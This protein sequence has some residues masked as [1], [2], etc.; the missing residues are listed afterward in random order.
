VVRRQ[1]NVDVPPEVL[2]GPMGSLEASIDRVMLV[3]S[4]DS[5][6]VTVDAI[7]PLAVARRMVPSVR[8]EFA[9]LLSWY[10]MY[11]FAFPGAA[12]T[13]I[14]EMEARLDPLLVRA[15]GGKAAR[16][17]HHPYPFRIADLYDAVRTFVDEG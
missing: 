4:H 16:V 8:Y 11:R 1:A 3:A 13:L 6:E 7:D 5:R 10:D 15:L 14:E 9:P 2:F 12:N 17:V